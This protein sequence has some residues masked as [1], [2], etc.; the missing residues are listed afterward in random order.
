MRNA[1]CWT[2]LVFSVAGCSVRQGGPADDLNEKIKWSKSE[3][4]NYQAA[5]EAKQPSGVKP[6]EA[7]LF[8]Q[9]K[10]LDLALHFGS[11]A[12]ADATLPTRREAELYQQTGRM[13]EPREGFF[14]YAQVNDACKKTV[15][16]KYG[17]PEVSLDEF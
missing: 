2:A 10:T 5:C 11:P 9:C 4:R 3:M 12:A 6:E 17:V 1:L 14:V 7:S 16:K 13:P 8:C 15:R